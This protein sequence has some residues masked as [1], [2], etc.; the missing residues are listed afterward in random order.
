MKRLALASLVLLLAAGGGEEQQQKGFVPQQSVG[1]NAPE[2][3]TVIV[4]DGGSGIAEW[5]ALF[6]GVAALIGAL[7]VFR[8]RR[9]RTPE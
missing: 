2:A 7:E 1:P 8:R 4:V 5:A 9:H 6:T 3:P